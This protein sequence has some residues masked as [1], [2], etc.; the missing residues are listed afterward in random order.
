MLTP[1][2]ICKMQETPSYLAPCTSGRV[3]FSL[4]YLSMFSGPGEVVLYG[5]TPR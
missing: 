5:A 4:K 2:M 3:F 1:C